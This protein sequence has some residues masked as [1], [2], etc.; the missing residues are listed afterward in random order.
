[1]PPPILE[2]FDYPAVDDGELEGPGARLFAPVA[3]EPWA[4]LLQSSESGGPRGRYDILVA[5][6]RARL[7]TR[8]PNTEIERD[9][10]THS[11]ADDPLDLVRAELGDAVDASASGLP[12]VGGAL[13]WLGYDLGRRYL[14]PSQSPPGAGLDLP[15]LCVGIYDWAL[16]LDHHERALWLVGQGGASPEA[17]AL[18]RGLATA[19]AAAAGSDGFQIRGREWSNM[20]AA[21]YRRRFER[22][23][24]YI[25]AGDCYQVNLARRFSVSAAGNP[26]DLYRLLASSNPAP[27][28]A[29]LNTPGGPV[30]SSSPERFLSVEDGEVEAR[31]I[32]GTR[33]RSADPAEDAA[34]GAALLESPK[35][36][37]E[38][39]MIVDLLRNDLGR[40][41]EVGSIGVPEL[42]T[43]ESFAQVHHL[44]SS[45]QGRLAPGKDALDLLRGAFP[46]GSIT[47]A[48]K[49]RAMQIIDELEAERRGPYCGSAFYLSRHGRFDSNILIRTMVADGERLHY[50]AGGG[51]VSDSDCASEWAEIEAKARVWREVIEALVDG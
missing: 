10:V 31:P 36:R 14:T 25:R 27:F 32:K 22:L 41:C 9:G 4:M 12:F 8:G 37:A 47:G 46:G 26:W 45:V 24:S 29:W 30:L 2:R 11:R 17:E 39:L 20:D 5:R 33:R 49:R 40:S 38:N 50:W 6:P 48:P 21:T 51:L 28:A 15:D 19:E 42:F 44:V 7:V 18:L 16:I 3:A 13:G 43:L 35:D 23:Q 1:M 34:L